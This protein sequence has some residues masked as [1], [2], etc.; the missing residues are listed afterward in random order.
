MPT[1]GSASSPI[2]VGAMDQL[3]T[4][5]LSSLLFGVSPRDAWTL[6]F[7]STVLAVVA[8]AA[9]YIPARRATQVDPLVAFRYE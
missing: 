7:V 4:R 9:C 5:I 3:G 6:L 1:G 2:E 8:V